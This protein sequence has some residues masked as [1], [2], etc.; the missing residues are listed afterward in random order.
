MTEN[1]IRARMSIQWLR[2][3]FAVDP[4][5]LRG[6]KSLQS[7]LFRPPS[8]SVCDIAYLKRLLNERSDR[9]VGVGG[10][11]GVGVGG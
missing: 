9:Y 4:R 3:R 1:V 10:V 2:P 6:F 11:K 8:S 5:A 7:S